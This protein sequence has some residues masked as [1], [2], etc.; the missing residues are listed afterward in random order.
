MTKSRWIAVITGAVAVALLVMLMLPMPIGSAE[1]IFADTL[2]IAL[3]LL[4][5]LYIRADRGARGELE[6]KLDGMER[7]LAE[8]KSFSQSVLDGVPEGVYEL[9][10]LP[11]NLEMAPTR[12]MVTI[13]LRHRPHAACI[14]PEKR[15][16]LT[17][18]GGLDSA[19]AE[20]PK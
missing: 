10:A 17:T 2:L 14:V 15:E 16:E 5:L 4:V 8:S 18:E 1:R 7:E 12:E 11:L 19:F 13:A 9:I 20:G 6:Q 3:I